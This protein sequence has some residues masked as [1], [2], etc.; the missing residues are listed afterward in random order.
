VKCV[1]CFPIAFHRSEEA[2]SD[3]SN[4]CCQPGELTIRCKDVFISPFKPPTCSLNCFCPSRGNGGKRQLWD[5]KIEKIL[6]TFLLTGCKMFFTDTSYGYNMVTT[7]LNQ[8]C[9]T[10]Y[11][12]QYLVRLGCNPASLLPRACWNPPKSQ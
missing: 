5:Y 1:L 8:N 10:L 6:V 7:G 3:S 9:S 12:Y 2:A 11:T 4:V